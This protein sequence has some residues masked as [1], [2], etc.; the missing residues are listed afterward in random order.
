M[1]T[2]VTIAAEEGIIR[3]IDV[4]MLAYNENGICI[5]ETGLELTKSWARS[6]LH[7]MGMIKGRVSS[8]AKFKVDAEN[9]D[10]IKEGFLLDLNKEC[11]V[12]DK[13]SPSLVINWDQTA[14]YYVP[15]SIEKEGSKRVEPAGKDDKLQITAV[16]AGTMNGD[17]LPV[18]LVYG[19]KQHTV[20]HW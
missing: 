14:I 6:L 11:R 15:M 13:I 18:Q 12:L 9:F 5:N 3:S 10:C 8:K 2:V 20:S 1:N 4:H 16:L 19:V 7:W 17:F